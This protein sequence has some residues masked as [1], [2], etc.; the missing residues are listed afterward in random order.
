MRAHM[1][2]LMPSVV[3]DSPPK[4]TRC[5]SL[6]WKL[7]SP[8]KWCFY[9]PDLNLTDTFASLSHAT[10]ANKQERVNNS[11]R[12]N[13][14][15]ARWGDTVSLV[16]IWAD[17]IVVVV[18]VDAVVYVIDQ[19]SC[20]TIWTVNRY[21]NSDDVSWIVTRRENISSVVSQLLR[22]SALLLSAYSC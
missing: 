9:S 6:W 13:D 1:H 14:A 8:L 17:I 16:S 7:T 19:L 11:S 5:W 10:T 2:W 12:A 3:R 20:W 15:I 22:I 4:A 21:R 18:V